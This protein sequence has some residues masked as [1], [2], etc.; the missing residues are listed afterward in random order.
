MVCIYRGSWWIIEFILEGVVRIIKEIIEYVTV[1]MKHRATL[2]VNRKKTTH[3]QAY[4]K[5]VEYWI[6]SNEWHGW[7]A[8][9]MRE[10]LKIIFS[11]KFQKFLHPFGFPNMLS[12]KSPG[13]SLYVADTIFNWSL[14][15]MKIWLFYLFYCQF[16]GE[17]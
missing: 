7:K 13:N 2:G 11:F 9:R 14:S 10:L 16:R 3:N 4:D 17:T 8:N 15:K 12:I 6:G 5:N 1:S